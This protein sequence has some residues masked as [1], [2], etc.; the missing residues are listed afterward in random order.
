[1]L[2]NDKPLVIDTMSSSWYLS[3]PG[4]VG[5]EFRGN[6]HGRFDDAVQQRLE[7]KLRKLTGG[8]MAIPVVVMSFNVSRFDG[9]N[10]A[11]RVSH[12]GFTKVF[13]YRGGREAWEVAGKPEAVVRPDD[14]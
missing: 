1:M 13:W 4:A 3:V 6:T 2:A 11:L 8:N 14:W 5:L 12:A 10:L 7:L 9:Y